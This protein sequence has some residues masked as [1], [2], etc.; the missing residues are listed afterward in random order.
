MPSRE[1]QA[2]IGSISFASSFFGLLTR[3]DTGNA[4]ISYEGNGRSIAWGIA[5]SAAASRH[6]PQDRG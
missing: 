5:V 6:S 4:V 2:A 3:F 1:V